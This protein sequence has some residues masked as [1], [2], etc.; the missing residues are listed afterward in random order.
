MI[1]LRRPACRLVG[2]G[3]GGQ[4]AERTKA[5]WSHTPARPFSLG[6]PGRA[7]EVYDAAAWWAGRRRFSGCVALPLPCWPEGQVMQDAAADL[8]L[9]PSL[10]VGCDGRSGSRVQ[11]RVLNRLRLEP[12][13]MGLRAA[14]GGVERGNL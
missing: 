10:A 5:V 11:R 1:R 9:E 4:D 13:G 14:A 12:F 2:R 3:F 8:G 6:R 7:N